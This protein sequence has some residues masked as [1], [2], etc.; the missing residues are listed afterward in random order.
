MQR[1]NGLVQYANGAAI[2][3]VPVTVSLA[4]GGSAVVYSDNSGTVLSQPFN[5][6]AYG[7]F[8]FY[9][10]DGRYT[11]SATHLGQVYTDTDVLLDDSLADNVPVTRTINGHALSGNI[12]LTAADVGVP[13]VFASPPALGSTT[14]AAVYGTTITGNSF[15]YLGNSIG[16][17]DTG[18][19]FLTRL[20]YNAAGSK[21]LW[22][23]DPDYI[24]DANAIFIR[25]FSANGRT[26]LTAVDGIN[27]LSKPLTIGAP[28]TTA[29]TAGFG[30]AAGTPWVGIAAGTATVAPVVL[31][32]GT[33]LT[34]AAAG[35]QEYDGAV[36][37]STPTAL[38]RGVDLSEQFVLLNAAYTLTSQTAAQKLFNAST[39][40]ALTLPI[41]TYEFECL[42]SL[43]SMSSTSGSFGF[44]LGGTATFTQEWY[45]EA[46]KGAAALATAAAAQNT[47]N[48]AANVALATASTNTVGYASINGVIRVTVAGTI[49]PQ[50]SLGVAAAAVV[51]VNS[52][53]RIR[54]LGSATVA[55]VGNWS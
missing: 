34:T 48:T 9:A 7:K 18:T 43:T 2:P 13:A 42:F 17:T 5:S 24:G 8:F 26:Q 45:A 52:Q 54:A 19:G 32:S 36:F 28:L 41:G 39:N 29:S 14:P 47:F 51:G 4:A 12:T 27:S 30:M 40:G 1:Y 20:G 25:L 55:A 50:V 44:A 23:G 53:F 33:N 46:Q 11:I 15:T 22:F 16:G 31:T 10:A 37:Y 49:I 21:Q 35:A 6:D 38:N 3:S